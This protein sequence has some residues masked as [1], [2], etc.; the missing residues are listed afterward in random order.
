MCPFCFW[1][2]GFWP[3]NWGGVIMMIFWA[4]ILVVLFAFLFRWLGGERHEKTEGRTSNKKALEILKERFARGEITEEEYE[5]M[6]R[7]IQDE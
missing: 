7:R 4:V 6:K 5:R 2:W 3:W 1:S